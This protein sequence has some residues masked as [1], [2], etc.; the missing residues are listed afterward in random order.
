VK[1]PTCGIW[2]EVLDTRQ[3]DQGHRIERR[4]LC[5]NGHRFVTVQIHRPVYCSAK[6]RQAKFLATA[7][8]RIGLHV[9][10]ERLRA[11]A[12]KGVPRRSLAK[13]AGI[14]YSLLCKLT[15]T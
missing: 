9:R 14:S 7:N 10:N 2:S 1:C 15:K 3:R 8:D 11:M 12:A 4:H 13:Q 5:A 6:Q